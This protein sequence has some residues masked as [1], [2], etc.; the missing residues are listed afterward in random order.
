[1]PTYNESENIEA[2]AARVRG[3][4]PA[5]DLLVVD[6][7]SPD[8]TGDLADKL[9]AEDAHIHVMHRATKAGLGA[10][11]TAGFRWAL[12]RGYGAIVEM[13]ADGSHRPEELPKLLEAL[14]GADLVIGS[15][16]VPGGTVVNWP[17]SRELL[18]RGANTYARL[19]LGISV[20]DATAGYRAYRAA[21]LRRVGLD[22][23]ESKG[24][25]FQIDLALRTIRAGL[26][27]VEVPITFVER[28]NG[29]SKMDRSV[30]AEAFWR[31]A[32]WGVTTRRGSAHPPAAK[33]PTGGGEKGQP[34]S[35]D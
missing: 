12:E 20:R 19:V 30:V 15:R 35:G 27:V 29:S 33:Q 2:M 3:A 6:D 31:V 23:I 25:C 28:V 14:S 11:Y 32:V 5:A 10:A 17:K 22:G 24:Y 34:P 8:G 1:M 21:T 16:Y 26:R 13:D 4:V 9:A 7:N 18:S